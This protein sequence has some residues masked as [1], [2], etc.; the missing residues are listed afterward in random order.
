MFELAI[1]TKSKRHGGT[2]APPIVGGRFAPV[3]G[4]RENIIEFNEAMWRR[5]GDIV[6]LVLGPPGMDQEFWMLHHPEAASRVLSGSTWEHFGKE[7]KMGDE[8]RHWFGNGLLNATGETWTSQKRTLQPLFTRKAVEGYTEAMVSE[9]ERMSTA[10]SRSG[11]GELDLGEQMQ[12]LT[13]RVV[14]RALFSDS[15]DRVV[16]EVRAAFPLLSDLMIRRGTAA[17]TLPRAVPTRRMSRARTAHR[18]LLAVCDDIIA[19]RRSGRSAGDDDMLGR[20]LAARDGDRALTDGE[21]RDQL[22]IFLLAGHETTS[23]ALTFALHLVGRHPDVQERL[24]AE[25]DAVFRAMPPTSATPADLP[26]AIAVLKETMRLFPSVPAFGR[27]TN[28]DD[29]ILGHPIRAGVEV[30]LFPWTIHR[31][32][33]FWPDPQRFDPERFTDHE[34]NQARH[35]YAWMPFS[36]GPRGCIGQYFSMT[37]AALALALLV[38]EHRFTAVPDRD[39]VRVNGALTLYP[40]EP[41]R[42]VVGVA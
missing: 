19:A 31:H 39:Q 33:D 34:A 1:A 26:Y 22:L 9:I 25:A 13:L 11:I 4:F 28:V 7:G 35:R 30:I 36:G 5:H 2:G 16:P 42:S 27:R 12:W 20:L 6:R 29:E 40:S 23:T 24:R 8:L 37:E 18:S 14:V 21:I 15:A 17:I 41:V 3:A 32:P 38:R 10:W